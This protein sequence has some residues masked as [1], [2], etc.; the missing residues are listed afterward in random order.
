[1]ADQIDPALIR[2]LHQALSSGSQSPA[3]QQQ[4]TAAPPTSVGSGA[5]PSLYKATGPQAEPAPSPFQNMGSILAGQGSLVPPQPEAPQ[6]HA[7]MIAPPSHGG[8]HPELTEA[9]KAE[10]ARSSGMV[11]SG[12]ASPEE[13]A[14]RMK[15]IQDASGK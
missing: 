15:L 5:A 4:P 7:P 2:S 1:M 9:Q 14:R 11:G 10:Q 3:G 12:T 6:Q 13:Q 8:Y